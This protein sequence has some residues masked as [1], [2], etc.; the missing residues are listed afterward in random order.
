MKKKKNIQEYLDEMTGVSSNLTKVPAFKF[1]HR[2]VVVLNLLR[3]SLSSI[4][5][6]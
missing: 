5:V 2:D 4:V 1:S 3:E 6:L